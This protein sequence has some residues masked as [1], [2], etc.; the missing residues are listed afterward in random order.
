MGRALS[1]L[2][3]VGVKRGCDL[4]GRAGLLSGELREQIT[5]E[6]PVAGHAIEAVGDVDAGDGRNSYL[7]HGAAATAG[8]SGAGL[9]RGFAQRRMVENM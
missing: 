8:V 5:I 9:A 7:L 3:V 4:S 2:A 1:G 6:A